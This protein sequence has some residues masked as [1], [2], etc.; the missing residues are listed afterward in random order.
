MAVR[1]A[2]LC[3]G[4]NKLTANTFSNWRTVMMRICNLRNFYSVFLFHIHFLIQMLFLFNDFV[5]KLVTRWCKRVST[6]VW[7][8]LVSSFWFFFL[9]F[10]LNVFIFGLILIYK[11]LV[12]LI[13]NSIYLGIQAIKVIRIAKNTQNQ[14]Q[15]SPVLV[16]ID[17]FF[18]KLAY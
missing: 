3:L 15:I 4:S 7:F 1:V 9:L 5:L 17:M 12:D 13:F 18:E 14:V 8:L 2:T 6:R 16:N 11:F 10:N